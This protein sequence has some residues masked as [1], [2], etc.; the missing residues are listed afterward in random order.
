MGKKRITFIVIFVF[1]VLA[2]ILF[3]GDFVRAEGIKIIP[4]LV[5]DLVESGEII[6]KTIK[7]T[8]VSDKPM[9]MFAMLMDFKPIGEKGKVELI[10][11]GLE[12]GAYISSWIEITKDSIEFAPQEEKNIPYTIV[13]PENAS[14]GGHYGAI[15][16]GTKADKIRPGDAEKGAAVSIAQQ[17]VSLLFMQVAGDIVEK[18][19]VKEFKT[20]KGI[21]STP[22]E[23]SFTTRIENLGNNHIAPYGI[24]EIK[25]MFGK[26]V[27][28]IPVNDKQSNIIPSSVRLF[29]SI[30]KADMGF[31]KYEA[32]L[33]LSYGTLAGRG[34]E[35]RK[36]LSIKRYFWVFPMKIVGSIAIVLAFLVGIFAW[37]LKNYKKKAVA[38]A[39]K[40]MGIKGK[41]SLKKSRSPIRAY[42]S[43]FLAILAIVLIVLGIVYFLFS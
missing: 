30:W 34:G 25:N 37:F 23:V 29:N 16:F 11:S 43:T 1:A 24:I 28:S 26:N 10:E 33:A 36:T 2:I 38:R 21:Y 4:S 7:V 3:P 40:Q 9:T 32:T 6:K 18:A 19:I 20:D 27:A 17:A 39:I 13:V 22:F 31:G 42:I 14:P 8:N 35:G 5:D 15:S 12:E 41:Y